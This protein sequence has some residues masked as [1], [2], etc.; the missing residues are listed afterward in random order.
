MVGGKYIKFLD[1][2]SFNYR[3]ITKD[4]SLSKVQRILK[5]D[6]ACY[7]FQVFL[8]IHFGHVISINEGSLSLKLLC[9]MGP[10]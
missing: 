9:F 5:S 8:I 1:Q 6:W 4:L 3:D 10:N 2:D 7:N